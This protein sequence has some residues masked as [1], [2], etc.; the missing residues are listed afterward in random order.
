MYDR[1]ALPD[2]STWAMDVELPT[3][4][5]CRAV[6]KPIHEAMR[7]MRW[8]ERSPENP[9]VEAVEMSAARADTS[10]FHTATWENVPPASR[11]AAPSRGPATERRAKFGRYVPPYV[12]VATCV[13]L[14]Y[15]RAVPPAEGIVNRNL[16]VVPSLTAPAEVRV[17]AGNSPKASRN[18]AVTWPLS[19]TPMNTVTAPEASESSAKTRLSMLG[20]TA[21][22]VPAHVTARDRSKN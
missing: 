20:L 9:V 4:S 14:E 8:S 21:A 3:S 1:G 2:G 17:R 13:P 12:C 18:L 5:T 19:L 6:G 11:C 22:S 15:R 7:A 10:E 16:R